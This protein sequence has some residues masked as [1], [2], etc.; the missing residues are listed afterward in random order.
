[1]TQTTTAPPRRHTLKRYISKDTN[2]E[3]LFVIEM[4]E[5]RLVHFGDG[6][7]IVFGSIRQA[8]QWVIEQPVTSSLEWEGTL[9]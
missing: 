6:V 4:P 8:V 2:W 5:G 9:F 7:P 1:M 3:P